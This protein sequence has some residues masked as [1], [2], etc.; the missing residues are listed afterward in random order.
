M[1][2]R[3]D[4]VASTNTNRRRSCFN[5]SGRQL[6]GSGERIHNAGESDVWVGVIISAPASV[7]AKDILE[8]N[9]KFPVLVDPR[10]VA[11]R[12]SR[13]QHDLTAAHEVRPLVTFES[14]AVA[15]RWV[16]VR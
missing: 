7:I 4:P 15:S 1:C 2:T 9:S 16:K 10:L 13:L 6:H 12:H 11:E 3:R 5:G 8:T 14:D